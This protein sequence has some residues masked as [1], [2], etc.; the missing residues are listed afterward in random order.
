MPLTPHQKKQLIAD[1]L[2]NHFEGLIKNGLLRFNNINAIDRIDEMKEHIITQIVAGGLRSTNEIHE[3]GITERNRVI[4]VEDWII[5][6][7]DNPAGWISTVVKFKC[8]DWRRKSKISPEVPFPEDFEPE[9]DNSIT[10]IELIEH[11]ETQS[12][13]SRIHK[14]IIEE[15]IMQIPELERRA[16]LMRYNGD[17]NTK[18]KEIEEALN[19]TNA[20]TYIKRAT[21]RIKN[22]LRARG[23][24]HYPF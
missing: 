17:K 21:K 5:N 10:P 2:Y 22:G 16:F 18:Y 23:I 24:T 6:T 8:I 9:D 3:E 20:G 12:E 7:N 4:I 15:V 13:I 14:I 19:I 11:S 1:A